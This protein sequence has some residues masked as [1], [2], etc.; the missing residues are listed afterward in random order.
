MRHRL[1]SWLNRVWY[2]DEK[3]PLWLMALVPLY[4][5]GFLADRWINRLRQPAELRNRAIVVTGNLTAGGS[6]KTPLVIRLCRVLQ[7]EGYRPGVVSRGYGRASGGLRDVTTDSDPGE[8]GDEPL[9]I[10]RRCGVPVVVA[11]DRCAAALSLFERGVD[12]VIADD[13][14]Q[15]HR[16]PRSVEICVIDGVRQ[17]GN[18]RLLPAGPLREP[19]RRLA[20]CDFVIMNAGDDSPEPAPDAAPNA[21]RMILL[22]GLLYALRG[23]ETWR[24]SQFRGC[25]VNAVAGIGNPERFFHSLRQAG[26]LVIPH[27]F[28][29]HHRFTAGDFKGL[30]PMLP[31]I[32]TEK[33]AVKCRDM[34][35]NNA[36]YLAIDASLPA[37]WE[38]A[39]LDRLAAKSAA[40]PGT[41]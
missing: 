3:P 23:D 17:F 26:L 11:R 41:P 14:L 5:A 40:R 27:V 32:M 39:F 34:N 6:G 18:G 2:G 31:V 20:R 36:W 21:T 28:P 1:E 7:R 10:A 13:G 4:R 25:R 33:D 16:L 15:H 19:R 30:E 9:V 37:S 22:P 24:L 38:T 12:V 35:L 29:D 8:T